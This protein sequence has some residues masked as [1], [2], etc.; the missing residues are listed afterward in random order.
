MKFLLGTRQCGKTTKLIE[1]FM[2]YDGNATFITH[3]FGMGR[4]IARMIAKNYKT[5]I[6]AFD[7][8]NFEFHTS[9]G[10]KSIKP[11]NAVLK[12]K[13][14]EPKFVDN[15]EFILEDLFQ[16]VQYASATGPNYKHL[17]KFSDKELQ[18]YKKI[19]SEKEMLHEMTEGWDD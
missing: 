8:T 1:E 16:N 10:I 14:N 6:R 4:H 3:N 2:N 13:T 5:L 19:L 18:E 7:S 9:N 11:A 15:F 12:F 17:K